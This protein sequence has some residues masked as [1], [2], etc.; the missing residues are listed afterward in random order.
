MPQLQWHGAILRVRLLSVRLLS[1]DI[2]ASRLYLSKSDNRRRLLPFSFRIQARRRHD[3]KNAGE[4]R[5]IIIIPFH[6]DPNCD[7][8]RRKHTGRFVYFSEYTRDLLK[9]PL[10]ATQNSPIFIYS[11]ACKRNRRA[12]VYTDPWHGELKIIKYNCKYM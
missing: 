3:H 1:V 2:A 7:S 8:S 6:F 4:R 5:K 11:H 12:R 9:S 10:P